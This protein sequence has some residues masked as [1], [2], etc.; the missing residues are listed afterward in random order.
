[1]NDL[2][3]STTTNLPLNPRTNGTLALTINIVVS[4]TSYLIGFLGL[5]C[6][7]LFLYHFIKKTK[8]FYSAFFLLIFVGYI[9]EIISLTIFTLLRLWPLNPSVVAVANFQYWYSALFMGPWNTSLALNRFTA[10]VFWKQHGRIWSGSFLIAIIGFALLYP[11]IVNG[12]VLADS[13]CFFDL[14]SP[15]CADLL[16]AVDDFKLKSTSSNVAL[17][18]FLGIFT[19]LARRLNLIRISE[20]KRDFEKLLLIHSLISLLLFSVYLALG[21]L[22][23]SVLNLND[24]VINILIEAIVQYY[25]IFFYISPTLLLFILS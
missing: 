5:L 7:I 16:Q 19:A 17:A 11:F 14:H 4:S 8:Y 24:S 9:M 21:H 3:V 20:D 2:S 1:M 18:A 12:Y 25:Y 23:P 10:I 22:T 15:S 13:A 6:F